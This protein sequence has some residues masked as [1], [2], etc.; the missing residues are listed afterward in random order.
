LTPRRRFLGFRSPAL[1]VREFVP[2]VGCGGPSPPP[3]RQ[4]SSPQALPSLLVPLHPSSGNR[5]S[6]RCR[7]CDTSQTRSRSSLL[8]EQSATSLQGCDLLGVSCPS[9]P[10]SRR[11]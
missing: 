9:T 2:T 5:A 3:P 10:P 6:E 8:L 7:V 4:P 11:L 1:Y